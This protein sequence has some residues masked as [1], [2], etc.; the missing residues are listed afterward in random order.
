MCN[1]GGVYR[2]S[3]IIIGN[4]WAEISNDRNFEWP[5][6]WESIHTGIQATSFY[7]L[8]ISRQNDDIIAGAQDNSTYFRRDDQWYNVIGGDGMECIIDPNNPDI[9]YGSSQYG[10]L[11]KSTN[12]GETFRN[13]IGAIPANESGAWT[14][15]F[16][17]SPDNSD[18][19]Y[20]GLGNIWSTSDGGANWDQKSDFGDLD[21]TGRPGLISHFNVSNS[22]SDI[23]YA[24]KRIQFVYDEPSGFMSTI[25]GGTT[26]NDYTMDLPDSLYFNYIISDDIDPLKVWLS[27]GGFVDGQKVFYSEDAGE[28]WKNISYN[29]PN[30]P[31]NCLAKDPNSKLNTVYAGTD[32]GIYYLND[33]IE[34]W[35][36][37]SDQLPNV[38]VSE[39][40]IHP[41]KNKIYAST[42]GRGIWVSD[43]LD[44]TPL[45]NSNSIDAKMNINI[46]PNINNGHFEVEI[47]LS[48][49]SQADGSIQLDIVNI[50]G[51]IVNTKNL[52]FSNHIEQKYNLDLLS[53]QY[54][55]RVTNGNKMKAVPFNIRP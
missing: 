55:L 15:P 29:M 12:R 14:T 9:I 1:D 51:M 32:I 16:F 26:W 20:V 30:I 4:T 42:F 54:Y 44:E 35:M 38:I 39:L 22:D 24:A 8:S 28:N 52:S 45:K 3:D 11:S 47:D 7:R 19:A 34:E 2:T 23:M 10:R 40:E 48:N 50:M 13:F 53:G 43:L 36:L 6:E 27:V 37:F 31:V 21:A 25:D 18:Q 46:S 33:E 49:S 17:V 5:T 41:G